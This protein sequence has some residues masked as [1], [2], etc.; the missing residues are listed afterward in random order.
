MAKP[1]TATESAYTWVYSKDPFPPN[2]G[3]VTH[4]TPLRSLRRT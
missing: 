3:N 1:V 2:A 4:A